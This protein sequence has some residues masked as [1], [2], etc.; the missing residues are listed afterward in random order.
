MTA[1]IALH[2]QKVLQHHGNYTD[3]SNFGYKSGEHVS[4]TCQS[5]S[6]SA[7]CQSVAS[8]TFQPVLD[9]FCLSSQFFCYLSVSCFS[10]LSVLDFF[11]LSSQFFCYLSASCFSYLS[12]S[13]S[14]TC[15]VNQ[16]CLSSRFFCLSSRFFCLS[17]L[18]S[19]DCQVSFSTTCQSI[20]CCVCVLE[21]GRD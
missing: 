9:F 2:L 12:V 7:T 5:V 6:S 15:Q 1:S 10:Y 19:S 3:A 18:S 13:Y 20:Y 16:F 17:S 14:A 21:N 11:C 8:S 4:S